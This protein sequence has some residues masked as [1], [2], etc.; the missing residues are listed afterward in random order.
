MN[1]GLVADRFI[2]KA[3]FGIGS[4]ITT[5]IFFGVLIHFISL[6][7]FFEIA[8]M[9]GPVL[10]VLFGFSSLLYNRSRAYPTGAEQRRSLYA[11][12]RSMQATVLFLMAICIGAVIATID[13]NL[14]S[15]APIRAGSEKGVAQAMSLFFAP[16]LIALLALNSFFMALQAVSHRFFRY[17]GLRNLLRRVKGG[18]ISR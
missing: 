5:A 7:A 8:A 18:R 12:E 6:G 10:A 17:V 11:A 2:F 9:C 16:I 14:H 15:G 4:V 3:I 13:W 1:A